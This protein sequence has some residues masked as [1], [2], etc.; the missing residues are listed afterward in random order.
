MSRAQLAQLRGAL[1]ES[2]AIRAGALVALEALGDRRN[3]GALWVNRGVVHQWR[4]RVDAAVDA[5]ERGTAILEQVGD[6]NALGI[7]LGNLGTIRHQQGLMDEARACFER[8]VE[9]ARRSGDRR[10]EAVFVANLGGL[11]VNLGNFEDA[12]AAYERALDLQRRYGDR[13]TEGMTL[14]NLGAMYLDRGLLDDAI[15]Q[16]D[17]GLRVLSGGWGRYA[18]AIR[19]NRASVAHL[20][21]LALQAEPEYRR[22]L[23]EVVTGGDGRLEAMIQGRLGALLSRLD[24]PAEAAIAFE[25]ASDLLAASRDAPLQVALAIHRSRPPDGRAVG[26]AGAMSAISFEVRLAERLFRAQFDRSS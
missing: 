13:G 8:A 9:I 12:L 21:G 17:E 1:D 24:R 14:G 5:L 3:V 19:A 10:F 23:S 18:G 26:E 2:D 16:F 15:H 7:A 22:A 4:H 6:R 20:R 25:R 11:H